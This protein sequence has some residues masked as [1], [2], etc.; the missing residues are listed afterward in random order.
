[1]RTRFAPS[2]TGYL[3]LGHAFSAMTAYDR[4]RAAGGQFLLRIEDTDQ[5]RVR[6]VYE[7]ALLEDLT[8]LGLDW[9]VPVLRQSD[10]L[11]EY[12]AALDR[13][14][15]LGLTYPCRCSRADIQAALSAP[16]EGAMGPDGPPYPGLCRARPMAA[17]A[18]GEAV[19]LNL[20]RALAHLGDLAPLHFTETGPGHT[21]LHRLDAD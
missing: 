8:W 9:P 7:A 15:A 16:Q 18:P 13:L 4:A 5:A 11:P 21:G 14:T 17:R 1:M 6:P 3:H 10:H 12:E 2:P 20:D 19:R